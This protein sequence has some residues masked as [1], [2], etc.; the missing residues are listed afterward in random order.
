VIIIEHD[1]VIRFPVTDAGASRNRREESDGEA[2][3][4]VDLTGRRRALSATMI[5]NRS[6]E[7]APEEIW[8]ALSNG[9]MVMHYQPQYDM[10]SGQTVAAEAL[11]R[12]LDHNGQI[13][14]PDR[15]IKSMEES[16]LIVL[17]GRDVIEHVC[18]DLAMA[19]DAGSDIHRMAINLSARQLNIDST[20]PFFIEQTLGRYGLQ[21]SDLEFELTE[22]QRLSPK[23][24]GPEVLNELAR[25]GARVVIDDFGIGFSSV[26]YLAEL[27]VSAFKLDRALVHRLPTDGTTR[28]LI[29]C[30]LNLADRMGL[31]VVAE[32]IET[33]AQ[34]ECLA[35][36]GCHYAQ[37]F[38]YA[39]PMGIEALQRFMTQPDFAVGHH[40]DLYS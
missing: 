15:F 4:V 16:D 7:L 13:I 9:R 18:A 1:N 12:L 29:K 28:T 24:N 22:R 20:L 38:A 17:L 21:H 39:R 2:A 36:A 10:R 25:Q 27:P 32:G 31:E 35:R 33:A 5:D 26:A 23:S 19:R 8:E 14:G 40:A 37:G 30:L 11:V 34:N 6:S 3:P